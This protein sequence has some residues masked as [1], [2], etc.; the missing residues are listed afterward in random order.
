MKNILKALLLILGVVLSSTS[1]QAQVI[2]AERAKEIANTFFASG[3]QKSAAARTMA[4]QEKSLD[5]NVLSEE[6]NDN[7]A[8]TYHVLTAA[9]G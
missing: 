1:A 7:E 2:T 4:V 3:A 6:S 5:N 8:P 9:D